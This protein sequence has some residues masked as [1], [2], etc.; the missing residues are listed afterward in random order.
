[1]GA[2]TAAAIVTGVG[3]CIVDELQATPE[4]GGVAANMRICLLAPGNVAWDGCDCGQLALSI[5]RTYPTQT[6]PIDASDQ[7]IIGNCGP[8]AQVFEVLVSLVR[9][10]PGLDQSGKPPSCARLRAASLIQQGDAFAI[11]NG[12]SCCLREL[13]RTYEIQKYTVGQSTFVGPEG[14]CGGVE[15]IFR[16]ELT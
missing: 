9:C 12:V 5:L 14:N 7:P 10:V 16:F 1:M 8:F 13:K 4:S 2:W 15:L 11:R 3:M 6:F